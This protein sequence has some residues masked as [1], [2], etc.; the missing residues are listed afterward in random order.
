MIND[1]AP[2]QVITYDFMKSDTTSQ[3]QYMAINKEYSRLKIHQRQ[4]S[5]Q[6]SDDRHVL[7][8]SRKFLKDHVRGGRKLRYSQAHYES[9]SSKYTEPEFV[10]SK[11]VEHTHQQDERRASME[12]RLR[13]TC[14]SEMHQHKRFV[15]RSQSKLYSGAGS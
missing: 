12:L 15:P 11:M 2:Q 14:M 8:K 7:D 4:K 13:Q 1:D 3:E 9:A 10:S 6:E 5:R